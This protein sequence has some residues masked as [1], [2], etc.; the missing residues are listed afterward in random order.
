MIVTLV[1]AGMRSSAAG[2]NVL[3]GTSAAQFQIAQLITKPG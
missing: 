2:P 3:P 1:I